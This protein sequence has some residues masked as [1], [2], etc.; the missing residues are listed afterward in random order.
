[1]L[2]SK[3]DNTGIAK[4]IELFEQKYNFIFPE[5][6]RNFLLKY[7]GGETP[8]S[9][10]K[11]KKIS[12]DIRAFYGFG[13]ADE[14]YHFDKIQKNNY[15]NEWMQEGVMPIAANVFGDYVMIGINNSN[16]GK[17]YFFYHDRHNKYIELS[18]DLEAFMSKCKS[19]KIGHIQ[20]IEERKQKLINN[21]NKKN[22]TPALIKIWKEQINEYANMH[23]EE[24]V[25]DKGVL[26]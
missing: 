6:Y 5:V 26:Q 15:F 7:N 11:I 24:I 8:K 25:L 2:I 22:I 20:T 17:I 16:K 9:K 13:Y 4:E 1:M 23:Q 19:E 18:E 3:F 10:F 21:G 12:S 14:H